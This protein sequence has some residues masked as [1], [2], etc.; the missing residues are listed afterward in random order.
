MDP[1]AEISTPERA[2]IVNALDSLKEQ[3]SNILVVGASE[4]E[5]HPVA[6]NRLLGSS[7]DET[8]YR[9]Y[10]TTQKAKSQKANQRSD[11]SDIER[12]TSSD[13]HSTVGKDDDSGS[14]TEAG[15]RTRVIDYTD[16]TLYRDESGRGGNQKGD[17]VPQPSAFDS[18]DSTAASEGRSTGTQ[19]AESGVDGPGTSQRTN[20]ENEQVSVTT[21]LGATGVELIRSIDD[22]EASTP[23]L[24]PS[25]IRV[26]VDSL[27]PLI[28]EN[29]SESVFRFLHVTTGRIKQARG[30]GHFHLPLDVDHD[31][32]NLF[33]PI[34]D[35]TIEVR[36]LGDEHEDEHDH[37]DE[38]EGHHVHEHR[39]Y[40]RDRDRSSDWLSL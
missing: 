17:S 35:A 29:E 7:D 14:V 5:A 4:S 20:A 39:W 3:G 12:G 21:R 28:D 40:L 18:E 6:C 24:E 38:D 26:C 1:D 27:V 8:R 30:M 25:A 16:P 13:T 36:S 9:L 34:F 37:E 31:V 32:V 22:I 10:V 23:H 2:W 33:E 11:I 19:N 15:T